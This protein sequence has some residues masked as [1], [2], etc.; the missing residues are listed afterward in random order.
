MAT[1]QV[2]QIFTGE[3]FPNV[4]VSTDGTVVATWGRDRY[5][6]R[7][8]EDGGA[9]WG[10][11][12]DVAEPGF[13]GGGVTVDEERGALLVFAE[14]GHPPKTPQRE[15]SPLQAF[16]SVDHG[17]HWERFEARLLPD[18][19]GYVPALHM[20]EHGV[21]LRHGLHPGRLL[22]PARV[23]NT[24]GATPPRY[25]GALYSD[26][27]GATWQAS[28]PFPEPG[29][30]EGALVELRD[31]SVYY[32]ARKSDFDGPADTYHGRRYAARSRDGGETW[33][34]PETSQTLPDGPRYRGAERRGSNFNGH[35]GMF[36]G[37]VRIPS[38]EHDILLYSNADTPTHERHRGT[39]WASFDGGRS[40]PVKRLVHEGPFAY[41]SLA[42]GRPGTSSEGYVWMLYEGGEN[43]CYEGGYIARFTLDW[44]R[45]GTLTGDGRLD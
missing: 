2:Q 3:R 37:L 44:V 5:R 8:S 4:V 38:G 31:G 9:T 33:L 32:S 16:R 30:G 28:A 36:A 19:N 6:V 45:D 17:R 34:A 18:R 35:F 13:H 43:D 39:V 23:Y 14:E 21:T 7:R 1:A 41:S 40:W 20:A 15:M 11:E 27:G 10:P 29:T 25:A 26:D 22:R 42:A 12:I 24:P